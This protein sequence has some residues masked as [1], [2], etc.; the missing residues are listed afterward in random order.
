MAI[1]IEFAATD[2][3][4]SSNRNGIRLDISRGLQRRRTFIDDAVIF[5]QCLSE[6]LSELRQFLADLRHQRSIFTDL[7]AGLLVHV[8][9]NGIAGFDVFQSECELLADLRSGANRPTGDQYLEGDTRFGRLLD[10]FAHLESML[11]EVDLP[12]RGV[13]EFLLKFLPATAKIVERGHNSSSSSR[14]PNPHP[15]QC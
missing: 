12:Q 8:D 4:L 11:T 5:C 9:K 7:I 2:Y 15:L 14:C 1:W 6:Q 3:G 13:A 10:L